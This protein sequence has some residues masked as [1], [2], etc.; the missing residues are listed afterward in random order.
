V[1]TPA[2]A[3]ENVHGFTPG[4]ASVSLNTQASQPGAPANHGLA[5]VPGHRNIHAGS[6]AGRVSGTTTIN[7]VP[8]ARVVRLFH[9][10]TAVLVAQ[11]WSAPDGAYSFTGLD[12]SAEYFAVAHDHLRTY[13]AVV[14]DMLTPSI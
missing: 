14:Q 4:Y 8:G 2:P 5:S 9:K 12:P 1:P 10:K 3:P 11:T 6:G 13:N 7:N